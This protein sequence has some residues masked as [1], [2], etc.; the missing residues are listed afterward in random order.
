MNS[1]RVFVLL[2]TFA[3]V[4]CD[5]KEV[6]LE[7]PTPPPPPAPTPLAKLELKPDAELEQQIA[8]IA[9]E[10]KGKVGVA[11]VVLET[12]ESAM[13]NG[14]QHFPMQSVYKLPIAMAVM[15]QVRRGELDLDAVIGVTKDDFIR[16]GMHSPL[17]DKNPNGGEFT[18][19][20]LIRLSLVESDGTASDVLMNT[21][22]GAVNVQAFLTQ[23]GIRDISVNNTEK[24]IGR[25]WETQYENWATPAAGIK[26]LRFVDAQCNPDRVGE[27]QQPEELDQDMVTSP[28]P[29]FDPKIAVR[30]NGDDQLPNELIEMLQVS[31][32]GQMRIKGRLPQ[33]LIVAHKTGTSGTRNGITA[34]TNDIG[35][36]SLPNG[37]HVAIA[38]FVSDSPADEKTREAVIAKIAK[39]AWDRWTAA[40]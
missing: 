18:I 8:K 23:I 11:A 5:G 29:C 14:D 21:A 30:P 27:T 22:G 26:I 15:D 2:F 25:D 36:I 39:A 9:E 31:V 13:F 16:P 17:R 35:I 37:N 24:E 28:D 12:G 6:R 1:L 7:F 33:G 4:G 19:R 3:L 34:A 32:P 20:E 38:V 40:N 10:A